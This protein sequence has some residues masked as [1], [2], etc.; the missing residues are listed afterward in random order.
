ML[1]CRHCGHQVSL[2]AGAVMHRTRQPLP[3]W[4]WA[5]YLVTTQTPGMSALHNFNGSSASDVTRRRFR[6]STSCVPRCSGRDGIGSAPSG[7]SRWTRR[8]SAARHRER[9]AGGTTRRLW[10]A[11]LRSERRKAL[12]L[13]PNLPSSQRP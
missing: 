10:W 7:Q 2:T 6:C 12:G 4:F 11:L 8:T 3:V 9:G 1:E 13:D 5:A